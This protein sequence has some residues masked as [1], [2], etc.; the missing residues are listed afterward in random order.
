MSA[1]LR[2]AGIRPISRAV[3]HAL[4]GGLLGYDGILLYNLELMQSRPVASPSWRL[5]LRPGINWVYDHAA[6]T[7]SV[8]NR[9]G[10]Y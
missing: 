3:Q 4:R 9:E 10:S 1:C 6:H 8:Q 5:M 7:V 2:E